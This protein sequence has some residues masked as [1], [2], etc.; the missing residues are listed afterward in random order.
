MTITGRV[1]KEIVL[2]S[3]LDIEQESVKPLNN[4]P[5]LQTKTHLGHLSSDNTRNNKKTNCVMYQVKYMREGDVEDFT[6]FK[7]I[8]FTK[9][10]GWS[11]VKIGVYLAAMSTIVSERGLNRAHKW[12]SNCRRNLIHTLLRGKQRRGARHLGGLRP[13]RFA[14]RTILVSIYLYIIRTT[15]FLVFSFTFS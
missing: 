4:H 10:K 11:I 15:C 7:V 12:D 1:N 14:F 2:R 5:L 8:Q 6:I 3:H 9:Q 13:S